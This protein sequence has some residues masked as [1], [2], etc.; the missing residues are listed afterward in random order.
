MIGAPTQSNRGYTKQSKKRCG[1]QRIQNSR[2]S[3]YT[4]YTGS[5]YSS[6]AAA[7]NACAHNHACSGVYDNHCTGNGPYK[8]CVAGVGFASSSSSCVYK[9]PTGT[10][11]RLSQRACTHT[12]QHTR[13][14]STARTN[15]STVFLRRVFRSPICFH[16]AIDVRT[17]APFL[18]EMSAEHRQRRTKVRVCLTVTP[19]RGRISPTRNT[20]H[21]PKFIIETEYLSNQI[22][23][24]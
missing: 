12:R 17:V 19:Q 3:Y 13:Q 22:R 9:K 6:L 1:K 23:F 4:R 21:N 14:A 2:G 11:P 18:S 7:S 15:D 10:H 16:Q 24:A 8:L 20:S 5:S